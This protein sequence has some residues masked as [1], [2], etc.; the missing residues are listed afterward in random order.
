[1]KP[2][3]INFDDLINKDTD[4]ELL[5]VIDDLFVEQYDDSQQN[6]SLIGIELQRIYDDIFEAN[7]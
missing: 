1:M 7:D 6:L 2:L 3:I 5:L 4:E